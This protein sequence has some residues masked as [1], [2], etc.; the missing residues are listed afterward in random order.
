MTGHRR[1]TGRPLA[2][3]A[4]AERRRAVLSDALA[5]AHTPAARIAAA[6]AHLRGVVV[7]AGP[8]TASSAADR[9]VRALTQ[10]ADDVL[11][12]KEG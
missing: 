11:T 7:H 10:I 1:R 6:A 9:A 8:S 3:Q 4:R 12:S 2:S 5:A